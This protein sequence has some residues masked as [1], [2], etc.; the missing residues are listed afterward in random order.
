MQSEIH[1]RETHTMI[2]EKELR[3]LS[4][5]RKEFKGLK[6]LRDFRNLKESLVCRVR[7]VHQT[8]LRIRE[9]RS[10][11]GVRNMAPKYA[12]TTA[13][14]KTDRDLNQ[15]PLDKVYSYWNKIIGVPTEFTICSALKDWRE[16]ITNPTI[17]TNEENSRELWEEVCK[18]SSPWKATGPDGIP[19]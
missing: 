13:D 15:I 19:N 7:L 16:S 4:E 12:I 10:K 11:K 6:K 1:R 9:E 2:S 14:D 18:S 8:I 3:N 17:V 5:I